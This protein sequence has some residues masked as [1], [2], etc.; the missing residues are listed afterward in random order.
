MKDRFDLL[1]EENAKLRRERDTFEMLYND[2]YK[3][4]FDDVM[5][6]RISN[7]MQVLTCAHNVSIEMF[8]HF[9]GDKRYEQQLTRKN[10]QRL[11]EKIPHNTRKHREGPHLM[12]I[13]TSVAIG[14][15]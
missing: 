9:E 15:I 14:D 11:M 6:K 7:D 8:R 12:S 13:I 4:V 10:L 5:I 1:A 3:T 2:L